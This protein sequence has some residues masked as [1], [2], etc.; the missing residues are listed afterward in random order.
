VNGVS[1][2]AALTNSSATA[3]ADATGIAAGDDHDDVFSSDTVSA[4]AKSDVDATSV[5]ASLTV[6]GA[7]VAAGASLANSSA[8]GNSIARA[9]DGGAGEDTILS[10]G[11]IEAISESFVD[12]TSVAVDV[13]GSL[14]GG[15]G[16]FA[17]TDSSAEA[18]AESTGIDGGDNNDQITSEGV[19]TAS[20]TADVESSSVSVQIAGSIGVGA[21]ASLADS[22]VTATSKATGID[23]G[24][25]DDE[26]SNIGAIDA[27]VATTA[28]ASSVSVSG[29]LSIGAG[30]SVSDSSV[31]AVS[32]A[33]G[34]S[35]GIGSDEIV[36]SGTIS[37]WS[38]TDAETDSVSV[39]VALAGVSLGDSSTTSTARAVG[40][41]SGADD[42]TIQNDG[43]VNADSQ[44]IVRANSETYL[45][46]IG[47]SSAEASVKSE[48]TAR[49][50]DGGDGND[51]IV[52]T[53]SIRVGPQ[54]DSDEE[55]W[56]SSIEATSFSLGI[57]GAAGAESTLNAKTES[58]GIDGGND[59]DHVTNEG[60]VNVVATSRGTVSSS[61]IGIFGTSDSAATV[62][63]ETTAT[64]LEGGDGDDVAVNRGPVTVTVKSSMSLDGASFEFGGATD[65][66]GALT[67]TT[68]GTGISGGTGV[69]QISNEGAIVVAATSVLDSVGGSSAAFGTSDSSVKSGAT[70]RAEGIDAGDND[71]TVDNS[72][73]ID[74]TTESILSLDGSS[75]TF[76]GTG[77]AGGSL[78][79]ATNGIG[80]AGGS[81]S[82][83]IS[84]A[85]AVAV[86]ARSE[87][88]STG[89]SDTAFGEAGAS[90][91]SGAVT[92]AAGIDGGDD[93][94]IVENLASVEV[95]AES[96]LT[97]NASSYT[98]GGIGE[99]DDSLTSSTTA[100]GIAG[101]SGLDN[102]YNAGDL[103]VDAR[104]TLVSTGESSA[105]FGAS[106]AGSQMRAE[107]TAAGIDGGD[108]DDTIENIATI[109][110]R[111]TTTGTT[112][113]A[114]FT[115]AG[116]A[117][118]ETALSSIASAVGIAGAGGLDNL[119]NSG[120]IFVEAVSSLTAQ[121]TSR[122]DFGGGATSASSTAA[123]ASATA[124]DGGSGN[125]VIENHGAVEVGA[126]ADA[127]TADSGDAGWLFGDSRVYSRSGAIATGHGIDAGD[128]NND[129]FN[130]GNILVEVT[131]HAYSDSYANGG[132]SWFDGDARAWAGAVVSTYAAGIASADGD[133]VIVNEGNVTVTTSK[134]VD[135][136]GLGEVVL[137]TTAQ[138]DSW[139]DG[140][141]IGGHGRSGSSTNP[142]LANATAEARGI[143]AGGGN[144]EIANQG[145]LAVTAECRA[146][147]DSFADGDNEAD[148]RGWARAQATAQAFGIWTGDGAD[149][150]VNDGSIQVVAAPTADSFTWES[151]DVCVFG[152]CDNQGR[153]WVDV[154]SLAIG[155]RTGGT[156]N[157]ITNNGSL[158]VT[159][160]AYGSADDTGDAE[161]AYY[162]SMTSRAI[163]I[164][165]GDGNSYIENTG[166]LVVTAIVD[167]R[168]APGQ[169][170][171]NTY[172]LDLEAIG[173]QTGN[174]GDI[175]INTG[176][177]S[178]TTWFRGAMSL[179]TAIDSGGGDDWVYLGTSS[180]TEGHID[181][182]GGD[183]SLTVSG[184]GRVTGT[185][186]GNTG[187]DSLI[188][189]DRSWFG[190]T[191]EDFERLVKDGRE[192]TT[193][194]DLPFVQQIA[195]THGILE[196]SSDC[197][198][199]NEGRLETWVHGDGSAGQFQVDG[200]ATLDGDLLVTPG[201][202]AFVDGTRFDV[203][204]ADAFEGDF[205]EV[206][207]PESKPL[208]SFE[209][210]RSPTAFEIAAFVE[211]F[212]SVATDPLET[213]IAGYMDQVLPAAEG[214]ASIVLGAFQRLDTPQFGNAFS[215][216]S[217][218]VHDGMT[219][220]TLAATSAYLTGVQQRMDLLRTMGLALDN[221]SVA[222]TANGATSSRGQS[223][224]SVESWDGFW[225]NGVGQSGAVDGSDNFGGF[226]YTTSG[227][228]LGYD[229]SL[230]NKLVG[231]TLGVL[232]TDV[233]FDD[234]T[235]QGDVESLFG[236][237]YGG[238]YGRRS[239][240]QS[241]LSYAR[242]EYNSSRSVE[243]GDLS[244]QATADH[245]GDA[246]AAVVSGGFGF[247][248][249]HWSVE[250]LGSLHFIRLSEDGYEESGAGSAGLSLESRTTNSLISDLGVRFASR[251]TAGKGRLVPD[252]RLSWTHDWG[253]DERQIQGSF[254]DV[255]GVPYTVDG[256]GYEGSGSSF[257]AGLTY[258]GRGG[259]AAGLRYFGY[260]VG[261]HSSSG[262]VG[263][264]QFSF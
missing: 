224:V 206:I 240:V 72:S 229:R 89:H 52:N 132:Q 222:S 141:G 154:E 204:T 182:G 13:S 235:A 260:Q 183:D 9:I 27:S 53:G 25:G 239:F 123:E 187:F 208:L 64:G 254:A 164:Q 74:V 179:G 114:A 145:Q 167:S 26:L 231:G 90:G 220:T 128:G 29:N 22:S 28:D 226:D 184:D 213:S 155:I 83:D 99:T 115:F 31:T 225:L 134:L 47:D 162:Y 49:G 140:D 96:I 252:L 147:V 256:R 203:L 40:I 12:A 44:S 169:A 79:A 175:I 68:R 153:D 188:L 116:S 259:W 221:E 211:P 247:G 80:I 118:D 58:T 215:N 251:I 133:D 8:V 238:L 113:K 130:D 73:T 105:D 138:A 11:D 4:F 65:L 48:A 94:D 101:G 228:T 207:L 161:P 1:L 119:V 248:S 84:N 85:G 70:T 139:A 122:S 245:D 104:S 86:L 257:G 198:L 36:N 158:T 42:D 242:H 186:T 126:W 156:N 34:I 233:G 38:S 234:V 103:I 160:D 71:D 17:M 144:N 152:G 136:S 3:T 172:D 24:S 18:E 30:G 61:S 51:E 78:S 210:N 39:T 131:S 142:V 209:L 196:V 241:V 173:I 7:G 212:R 120:A 95:E 23:G 19:I 57:V 97:L 10:E 60:E 75:F 163:G 193:L 177:I 102:I 255:P 15:A 110:V 151:R 243:F 63:A 202:Q 112:S 191:I 32:D 223:V 263:Q 216:L 143:S 93:D 37:A 168:H 185:V 2:S 135:D 92:E 253:I 149:T 217:P 62:T 236:T 200:T 250:P 87:L 127:H 69:D 109:D 165:A 46:G 45:V 194:P 35:G 100:R 261:N 166:D 50:I 170:H 230:G 67:A 129:V 91:T 148:G 219:G 88:H 171:V 232:G 249:R 16:G 43:D 56:M 77:D 197:S 146:E 181:L 54:L 66:G 117:S 106:E 244:R 218:E 258:F 14:A 174:G 190:N 82:D 205:V 41:D 125:D 81:G 178:A 20:A 6:T 98:F 157:T 180:V 264:L 227:Y 55:V 33:T 137:P 237:A 246:I 189:V 192:T 150:I 124:I 262:L 108:D 214:D 76:G 201:E 59:N 107:V 21:G 111:S 199:Q 159:S 195:V 5:S 176:D 121:G